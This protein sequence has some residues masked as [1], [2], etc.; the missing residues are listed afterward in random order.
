MTVNHFQDHRRNKIFSFWMQVMQAYAFMFWLVFYY[1]S[2]FFFIGPFFYKLAN[3]ITV[4]ISF[5]Q[6]NM[7]AWDNFIH[8]FSIVFVISWQAMRNHYS[9]RNGTGCCCWGICKLC[10]TYHQITRNIHQ[11]MLKKI[12]LWSRDKCCK[13]LALVVLLDRTRLL[14]SVSQT[15]TECQSDWTR[16]LQ[17]VS[18]TVTEC[19]LDCY[20]VSVRLDQTVT[21]CQSDCY[22]VSIRLDQ[23]VIER[24][25]LRLVP[26]C[27]REC[28]SDWTRL[29]QSVRLDQTVIECQSDWTRLLQSVNQT[30]PDC[31][32]ECQP[33]CSGLL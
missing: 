17:N 6:W 20:R 2:F 16:L 21:E 15:V 27:Y 22:R 19:Q 24:V 11:K 26:N 3:T 14:Q 23:T 28:Q 30:R 1:Y 33:D 5:Q 8:L 12:F 10:L 32:R 4:S 7:S 13:W 25:S 29:L 9:E 18:R 31:Y